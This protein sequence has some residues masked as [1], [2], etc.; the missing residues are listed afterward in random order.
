MFG[1][2]DFFVENVYT[3][4][5][6]RVVAA[7]VNFRG[8]KFRVVGV[9][10]PQTAAERREMVDSMAPLMVTNRQL[11]VW[12]DFNAVLDGSG[13]ASADYVGTFLKRA[14]LY[15]GGKVVKPSVDGPTWRNTRGISR[16]L[17]LHLCK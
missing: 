14:A 10:G 6:G 17:E 2:R 11:I 12:G 3:I 16:R 8:L 4:V 15:D 1:E 7:D 9:Y 13:D 5:Q